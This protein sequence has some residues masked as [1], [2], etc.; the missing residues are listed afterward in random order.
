MGI[1]KPSRALSSFHTPG[2]GSSTQWLE[3]AKYPSELEACHALQVRLISP[4][5]PC[6]SVILCLMVII[7]L[8]QMKKN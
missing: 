3:T 6:H 7:Y 1:V 5:T 8:N 2:E 4:F